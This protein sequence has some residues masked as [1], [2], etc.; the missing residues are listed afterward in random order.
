M[1]RALA[2]V[3][4][5]PQIRVTPPPLPLPRK[6]S[7]GPFGAAKPP[8]RGE[9]PIFMLCSPCRKSRLTQEQKVNMVLSSIRIWGD[10]AMPEIVQDVVSLVTISL[11]VVTMAAWVGAL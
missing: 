11:F 2:A 10:I 3:A 1:G 4:R 6:T 7:P 5:R 9:K 8:Q